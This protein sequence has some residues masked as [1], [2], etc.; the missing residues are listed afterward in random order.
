MGLEGEPRTE[1][2]GVWE[3][4]WRA[5]EDQSLGLQSVFSA[6]F[7][8]T[9][10]VLKFL[11][12]CNS[13]P[14]SAWKKSSQ[15]GGEV[16]GYV[17]GSERSCCSSQPWG[18]GPDIN[19]KQW[20]CPRPC[21]SASTMQWRMLW[22]APSPGKGTPSWWGVSFGLFVVLG[23]A[24][25]NLGDATSWSHPAHQHAPVS[26]SLWAWVLGDPRLQ[27]AELECFRPAWAP[28]CGSLGPL[29]GHFLEPVGMDLE[30]LLPGS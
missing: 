5:G 15:D 16:L 3:Q 14:F 20:C 22:L 27:L 21:P 13:P 10:L 11:S 1:S 2:R 4:R 8:A 29:G 28:L 17:K 12:W 9:F 23:S 6:L 7:P 26:L 19:P 30:H 25:W 24:F 18:G